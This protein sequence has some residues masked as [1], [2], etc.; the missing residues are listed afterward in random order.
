MNLKRMTWEEIKKA[1]PKQVVGLV[2]CEPNNGNWKTAVVKYTD[3]TTPYDIM[4]EKAF[5]GE[6]FIIS[7]SI[8]ED[9]RLVL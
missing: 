3:A 4:E 6:I 7:T 2:D 9:N 5:D 8:G 1:Y